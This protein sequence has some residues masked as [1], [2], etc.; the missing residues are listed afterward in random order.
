MTTIQ[1]AA[2][3]RYPLW[4]APESSDEDESYSSLDAS[5]QNAETEMEREAFIAGAEWMREQ[6]AQRAESVKCGNGCKHTP[7]RFAAAIRAIPTT[8]EE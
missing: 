8:K 2:E 6:A 4:L 3:E 5:W 7:A 1:Q